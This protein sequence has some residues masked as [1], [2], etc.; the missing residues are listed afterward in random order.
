M[1]GEQRKGKLRGLK[2]FFT[3]EDRDRECRIVKEEEKVEW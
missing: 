2:Q 1:T 3:V